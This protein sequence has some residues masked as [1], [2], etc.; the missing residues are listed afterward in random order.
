MRTG[1]GHSRIRILV[2]GGLFTVGMIAFAA[3]PRSRSADIAGLRAQAPPSLRLVPTPLIPNLAEFVLDQTAAIQLGKAL[4]WEMQAGSDGIQACASC[5]FHAGADS[6]VTGQISPG[7]L[8]GDTT[9]Q[10]GP[11]HSTL[12]PAQFP[13]HQRQ[14]PDLQSSPVTAD[15][16]DVASSQGVFFS[17]FLDIVPGSAVDLAAPL[18]DPVF[19]G[20]GIRPQLGPLNVR[21]VEPRNTPTVINAGFHF[22]NFWDGRAHQIFNGVNPFGPLDTQSTLLVNNNGILEP[23]QVR[24]ENASLASQ[25]V[26]PPLS[27]F[28]MS[29][30]GRTFPKLGKKM[31]SLTPLAKQRVHPQ[32]SV[33]GP[34]SRSSV[35]RRGRGLLR[36]LNIS[37]MELIQ[38]AFQPKWWNA[39]EVI[40][41][42][43]GTATLQRATPTDPRR[44][45]LSSGVAI[46]KPHPG[47]PLTT[48]EFTQMEANFSLFWGLAID[49]YEK[50]LRSDQSPYDRFA[51]GDDSALTPQ[52]LEGLDIF[53]NQGRCI[54]CH[55]GPEFTKH[56]VSHINGL[57]PDPNEPPPAQL[58]DVIEFMAM[59]QG[60]AIYDNGMYNISFRPTTDDIGRGGNSPF[61]NLLTGLPLPLAFTRLADL[62][63]LGLLPFSTFPLPPGV[64]TGFR[65]AADGAMKTSSLRNIDLTGPYFHS[66]G[67]AT[68]KQVVQAYTRGMN[69]PQANIDNLDPDIQEIGHLQG[70]PDR[71]D[72]LVAFLLALTDERVRQEQDVFD[73]PEILVPRGI[74][75]VRGGL[76]RCRSGLNAC[77]LRLLRIPAVGAGGRPASGLSPLQ[78]F[79]GLSPFQP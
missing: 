25:A 9:F 23:V 49:L 36:G 73:H 52:Q 3:V 51:E 44:P 37:Y 24:I 41:F 22:N 42:V 56:T 8:A 10:I 17:Q 1:Q 59:A 6:R 66:G 5:H 15:T 33:L 19:N 16:N 48:N 26:G 35:L 45:I 7:L 71:Q 61:I 79:L 31:L 4:F 76:I 14:D 46:I 13:F 30:Q 78:P 2:V 69:F 21:R 63:A 53:L 50:T 68:L 77:E 65:V 55:G 18:P 39:T 20:Q 74:R 28:E 29:A 11:P 27:D 75:T 34:L 62:Q 12:T 38:R 70:H 47:R 54:N 67:A 32:D 60:T 58:P 57:F 72:A 43:P 64:P 40:E